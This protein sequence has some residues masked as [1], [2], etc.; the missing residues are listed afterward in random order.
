[1]AGELNV[2]SAYFTHISHQM[3]KHAD[4]MAEL[5]AGRELAFD[6][7]ELTVDGFAR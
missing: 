1:M 2:P 5:P 6:G 3:G 4:V 7:L